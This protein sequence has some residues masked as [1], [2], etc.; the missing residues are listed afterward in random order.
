MSVTQASL[1]ALAASTRKR[2]DAVDQKARKAIKDMR[3]QNTPITIS[4]VAAPGRADPRLALPAPRTAGPDPRPPTPGRGHRPTPT[5]AR[6]CGTSVY[7][8]RG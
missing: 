5:R 7:Y 8:P 4:A 1:D 3:R 6:P 2:R